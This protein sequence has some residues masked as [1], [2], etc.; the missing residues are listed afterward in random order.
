MSLADDMPFIH[1]LE[2][3]MPRY[4]IVMMIAAKARQK[5]KECDYHITDSQAITWAIRGIAPRF[6]RPNRQV[7]AIS[8]FEQNYLNELLCYVD[9]PEVQSAVIESYRESKASQN[10][11]YIYKTI[12]D[13]PRRARVR[14]LVRMVWYNITD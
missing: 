4:R 9:D 10:L 5:A 13:E 8:R 2:K 3:T 1:E 11:V 14:V 12:E 7:G 6:N